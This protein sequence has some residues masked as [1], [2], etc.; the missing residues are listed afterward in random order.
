MMSTWSTF[1]QR[2]IKYQDLYHIIDNIQREETDFA[3]FF[4]YI[5]LKGYNF[6]DLPLHLRTKVSDLI[7]SAFEQ[8]GVAT[9]FIS[10]L[11][12]VQRPIF[13]NKYTKNELYIYDDNDNQWHT[14]KDYLKIYDI[15]R[16]MN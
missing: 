9:F 10:R 5:Q 6:N 7:L 16:A 14:L 8:I 15:I 11:I 1:F 4:D 2:E 3:Y 13:T 12:Q